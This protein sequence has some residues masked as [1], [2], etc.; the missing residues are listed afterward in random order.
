[1]NTRI[2]TIRN[3]LS[4]SQE[5]FAKKLNISR[6]FVWMIEKG[7]R[8]PSE[9]TIADICRIFHVNPDWIRTGQGNM[10]KERTREVEIAEMTAAMY[11]AKDT[12]YRYQ[13]MKL[14]ANMTP[15]QI[16]LL[17]KIGEDLLQS[18][19]AAEVNEEE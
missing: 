1:M 9:R 5:E 17:R 19:K 13:L 15:E 6:N 12:D 4:L 14:I 11:H 10:F 3:E 18:I 8:E 7:E 2:K 16:E